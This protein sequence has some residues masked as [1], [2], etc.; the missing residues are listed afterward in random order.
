MNDLGYRDELLSGIMDAAR[1]I[2]YPEVRNLVSHS[3]LKRVRKCITA[4]GGHFEYLV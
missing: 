1:L 2:N 3:G 4:E